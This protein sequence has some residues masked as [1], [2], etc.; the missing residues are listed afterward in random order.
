M[1]GATR[2]IPVKLMEFDAGLMS[3]SKREYGTVLKH[4]SRLN[5]KK[6]A[7]MNYDFVS[8]WQ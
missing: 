4:G 8:K 2:S 1:I 6:A 5:G 3:L 7:Y